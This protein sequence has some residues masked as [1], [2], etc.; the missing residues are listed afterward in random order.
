MLNIFTYKNDRLKIKFKSLLNIYTIKV[1]DALLP[2]SQK[3]R[4]INFGLD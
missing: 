2:H 1:Q 3:S 4:K